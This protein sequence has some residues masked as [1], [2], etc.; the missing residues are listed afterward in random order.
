MCPVSI[1]GSMVWGDR[2]RP[3]A[4]RSLLTRLSRR[5]TSNSIQPSPPHS[6]R[7]SSI[8][9]AQQVTHE[10]FSGTRHIGIEINASNQKIW[11]VF[12]A[13]VTDKSS[14]VLVVKYG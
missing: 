10:P 5:H 8:L 2:H 14:R 1:H 3:S 4:S 9:F 12:G 6:G 13:P 11:L 7:I